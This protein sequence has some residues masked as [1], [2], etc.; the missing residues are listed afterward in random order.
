MSPI[1]QQLW[2]RYA[3]DM[4]KLSHVAKYIESHYP[5]KRAGKRKLK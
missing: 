2:N 3:N 4:D 1:Q 5:R